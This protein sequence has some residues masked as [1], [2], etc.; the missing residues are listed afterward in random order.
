MYALYLY[1]RT[2]HSQF[3]Y[4]IICPSK[5]KQNQLQDDSNDANVGN[6]NKQLPTPF[7]DNLDPLQPDSSDSSTSD[8]NPGDLD[9]HKQQDAALQAEQHT[10]AIAF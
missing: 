6:H 1:T 3:P 5:P 8:F 4:L 2:I 7:H 10:C 9:K